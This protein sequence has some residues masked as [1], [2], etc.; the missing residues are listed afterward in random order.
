M[1]HKPSGE[2]KIAHQWYK[3]GAFALLKNR[4][5]K[6]SM[7][8]FNNIIKKYP[9]SV[10]RKSTLYSIA[11]I[12]TSTKTENKFLEKAMLAGKS[13]LEEYPV[14][15]YEHI[16]FESIIKYYKSKGE[17]DSAKTYFEQ[18]KVKCNNDKLKER[19]EKRI[20]TLE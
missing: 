5:Y 14:V 19:I 12:G 8:H 17:M 11:L 7:L 16:A 18:L 13:L 2:E 4:D 9:N 3:E 6:L 20:Q 1:V 15:H 10:Y